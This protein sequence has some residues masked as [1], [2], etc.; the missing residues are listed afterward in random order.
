MRTLHRS[1]RRDAIP[2]RVVPKIWKTILAPSH[3]SCLAL[4]NGCSET[5]QV[6]CCHW[7][8]IN[9]A[10]TTKIAAWPHA[11]ESGCGRRRPLVALPKVEEPSTNETELICQTEII[12]RLFS[13]N[14]KRGKDGNE[15]FKIFF[16][17]SDKKKN[18]YQLVIS[19][20][21][22]EEFYSAF[23]HYFFISCF[24]KFGFQRDFVSSKVLV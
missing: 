6:W 12:C 3:A 19:S 5:D 21:A 4:M 23:T 8:V 11:H 13:N 15:S 14:A 18:S 9:A 17:Y 7:Y 20:F 2:G 16:L 10:L 24:V 1:C 22:P